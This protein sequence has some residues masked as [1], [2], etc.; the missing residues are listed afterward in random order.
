ML[1]R[2]WTC[3]V[4]GVISNF[5]LS[6]T[7]TGRKIIIK[8][9]LAISNFDAIIILLVVSTL[10]NKY[11]KVINNIFTYIMITSKG[12]N[13]KKPLILRIKCQ[14]YYK[15]KISKDKIFFLKT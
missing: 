12:S 8:T 4:A 9:F 2:S 11:L 15:T 6:D 14:K 7:N 10:P 1:L 13:V 3:Y 5:I